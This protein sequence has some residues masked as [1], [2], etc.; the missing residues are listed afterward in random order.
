MSYN[1]KIE[2]GKMGDYVINTVY[3]EIDLIWTGLMEKMGL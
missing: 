1:A 3:P 2:E